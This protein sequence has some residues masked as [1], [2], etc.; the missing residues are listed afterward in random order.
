M[1]YLIFFFILLAG[2]SCQ[3]QVE[4]EMREENEQSDFTNKS[5][6]FL[7]AILT[8]S[9]E[10]AFIQ[11]QYYVLSDVDSLLP[12]PD[13]G[14]HTI[15]V[16]LISDVLDEEDQNFIEDQLRLRKDFSVKALR[17]KGF[18]IVPLQQ[19]LQENGKA[20]SLW[21][22]INDQYE[23]GFYTV[24]MPIFSKG[25]KKAYVRVGH[26]CGLL[27]GGGETRIYE[28]VNGKWELAEVVE[29]WVS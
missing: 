15:E 9:T 29:V 25:F 13:F 26:L 21:A 28:C 7:E 27:C 14:Q 12:P 18:T 16:A 10:D 1:R 23:N 4:Q 17:S 6:S 20:D 8:D 11:D 3:Q 2:A 24:S 22:S 19:L 5:I